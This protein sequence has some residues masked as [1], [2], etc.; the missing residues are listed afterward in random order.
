MS[1][2]GEGKIVATVNNGTNN[3]VKA[4]GITSIGQ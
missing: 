2:N 1:G 4:G 3:T